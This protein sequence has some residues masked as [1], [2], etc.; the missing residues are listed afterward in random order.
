M[1]NNLWKLFNKFHSTIFSLAFFKHSDQCISKLRE[2]PKQYTDWNFK[3]FKEIKAF[4]LFN[5]EWGLYIQKV[6]ENYKALK[7]NKQTKKTKEVHFATLGQKLDFS[8]SFHPENK[9]LELIAARDV[10]LLLKNKLT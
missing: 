10:I 9:E 3:I 8:N 5:E 6:V 1:I 4:K 2:L 7:T